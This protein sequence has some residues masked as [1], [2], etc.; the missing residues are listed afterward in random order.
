MIEE[1]GVELIRVAVES[2][3]PWLPLFAAIS[4]AIIGL[5]VAYI[6]WRQHSVA[7]LQLREALF[8]R[9]FAVY[10]TAW[11]AVGEVYSS[12]SDPERERLA[13]ADVVRVWHEAQFLFPDANVA[14][15]LK[16]LQ[17]P[18]NE[19]TTLKHQMA[20]MVE[21]YNGV[22]K[23]PAVQRARKENLENQESVRS[24]LKKMREELPNIFRPSLRFPSGS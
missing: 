13:E 15:K 19:L 14:D 8:D 5:A 21:A 12:I 11:D 16:A 1:L 23:P 7:R 4:S 2:G 20:D 3:F 6:A 9:R 24:M 10:K 22:E 18:M 17:M